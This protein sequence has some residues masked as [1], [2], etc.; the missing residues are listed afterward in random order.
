MIKFQVPAVFL[1]GKESSKELEEGWSLEK[2]E[3]CILKINLVAV[4]NQT[5]VFQHEANHSTHRR[6]ASVRTIES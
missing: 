2:S 3:L 1:P 4:E 5:V 6:I